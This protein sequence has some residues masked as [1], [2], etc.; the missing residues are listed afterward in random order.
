MEFF[1]EPFQVAA[2]SIR[3]LDYVLRQPTSGQPASQPDKEL[4]Q[5]K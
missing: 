3:R 5:S 1:V 2:V 4:Y